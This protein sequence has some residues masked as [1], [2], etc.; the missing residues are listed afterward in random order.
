MVGQPPVEHCSPWA[1]TV[2][3]LPV[4]GRLTVPFRATPALNFSALPPEAV[5]SEM[6][7]ALGAEVELLLIV[8]E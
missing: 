6:V 2:R 3:E 8:T 4:L 1:T 5:V 7:E